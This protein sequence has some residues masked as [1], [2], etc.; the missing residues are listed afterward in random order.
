[1]Y[2]V[3]VTD[4]QPMLLRKACQFFTSQSTNGGSVSQSCH[5]ALCTPQSGQGL[6]PMV[7]GPYVA[8]AMAQLLAYPRNILLANE[9]VT[10]VISLSHQGSCRRVFGIEGEAG[11]RI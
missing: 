10:L 3:R 11:E 6:V 8:M 5:W 4:V 1:M 7:L 2:K 9:K